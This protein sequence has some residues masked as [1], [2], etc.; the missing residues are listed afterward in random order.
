MINEKTARIGIEVITKSIHMLNQ[1]NT[2]ELLSTFHAP[3]VIIS[4]SETLI[5]RTVKELENNYWSDF[6]RRAG[7]Q[8]HHTVIDWTQPIHASETKA[9]IFMQFSRYSADDQLLTCER[10][11][12]IINQRNGIWAAHGRSSFNTN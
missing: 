10:A 5:Y 6:Y 9:H 1:R 4:E 12:W 2:Q 3:H 8:W 7:D 11:L